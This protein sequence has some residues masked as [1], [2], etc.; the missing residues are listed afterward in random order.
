MRSFKQLGLEEREKIYVMLEQ[1]IGIR[2]IAR[3]IG[4][5]HATIN[6]EIKRNKIR[7]GKYVACKAQE[8]ADKRGKAQRTKSPLKN[9][10]IFLYVR[11][12]LRDYHWTPQ[13]ISGRIRLEKPGCSISP[14]TIYQ[15]IYGKGKSYKLWEHLKIQRPKCM[16]KMGRKVKRVGRIAN[17][18]SIELRS[19]T[20]DRRSRKGD[21]ESDL[22]VGKQ[23]DQGALNVEYERTSRFVMLDK[24]DTRSA[25]SKLDTQVRRYTQLPQRLRRTITHDNGKENSYHQQLAPQ[26]GADVYFT[27]P[28]CS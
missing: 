2:Q 18:K 21:W 16:K 4:K 11:E 27:N 25:Q 28:Y 13:Q 5:P 9:P 26:T 15:Y 24:L 3:E 20:V 22:V 10:E 6:R 12:H 19:K 8:K 1:G 17:A 23:S 7:K 14:E